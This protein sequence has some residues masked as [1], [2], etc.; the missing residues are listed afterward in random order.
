MST[1]EN[2][3]RTSLIMVR[4]SP[5]EK[6]DIEEKAAAAENGLSAPEFLRRCAANKKIRSNTDRQVINELRRLGGLQKKIFQ[7]ANGLYSED[8]NDVITQIIRT[9]KTISSPNKREFK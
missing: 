2:R 5:E 4:V 7:E 9:I 8:L 3:K 6:L 1:S